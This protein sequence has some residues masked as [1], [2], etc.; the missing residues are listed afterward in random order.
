LNAAVARGIAHVVKVAEKA[1][2]IAPRS[3]R[4]ALAVDA[5]LRAERGVFGEL[6]SAVVSVKHE[7]EIEVPYEAAGGVNGLE[8]KAS[9]VAKAGAN[10]PTG[11]LFDSGGVG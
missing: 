11:L 2:G 1:G 5:G 4:I 10:R 3:N 6:L 8:R 9:A 7:L